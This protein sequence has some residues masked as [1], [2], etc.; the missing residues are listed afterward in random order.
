MR[1]L[2]YLKDNIISIIIYLATLL[3]VFLTLNAFKIDI[4]VNI[5]II[6]V[7]LIS[8]ISIITMNYY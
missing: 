6:S 8:G 5:I 7:L 1:Y 4:S 2:E 3:L